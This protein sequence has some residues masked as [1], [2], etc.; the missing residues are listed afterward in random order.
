MIENAARVRIRV[1]TTSPRRIVVPPPS[2]AEGSGE[3][4]VARVLLRLR[5][6][7]A[8]RFDEDLLY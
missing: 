3:V 7:G 4:T 6:G 2:A 5:D 8:R 1:S